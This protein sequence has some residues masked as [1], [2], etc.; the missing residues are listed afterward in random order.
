MKIIS[1]KKRNPD[2]YHSKAALI[3]QRIV[4][5]LVFA[6]MLS[7]GNTAAAKEIDGTKKTEFSYNKGDYFG[8]DQ[9]AKS[10]FYVECVNSDN[11]VF[12]S[13]SGFV[14]FDE[15]LFVTNQHVI[16]DASYLNIYDDDFNYYT[17]N[18]VVIS[19]AE[20]DIAILY[21]PS[22]KYYRSLEYDTSFEDLKRGQPILAIGSPQGMPGTVSDGIISAFPLFTGEDIR[23]IQITAPI[24]H[25]SS[26]GCLLNDD[27]KVIGVTSGG[28]D[29]GE[30]LGFAIPVFIVEEL[31]K[32]WNKKDVV[33]LG[34]ATSWDTVGSGLYRKISG[35][36]E[37][38]MVKPAPSPVST[39]NNTLYISAGQVPR[40]K[41]TAPSAGTYVFTS[42]GFE[43]T[44]G[45]LY[46]SATGSE[47]ASDDDSGTDRNFR[48]E[49]NLSANETI[50]IGVKY[51]DSSA[52][53]S[54]VLN[55]SKKEQIHSVSTGNNTISVSAGKTVRVSF[56][57]SSAG[58]YS[59]TTIGSADTYGYLYTSATGSE[60]ASDDDSGTDRN[61]RLERNLSANETIYIG[62]KYY[63]SSASGN[64]SLSINKEI[65]RTFELGTNIS[66]NNGRATVS[67]TDSDNR[68]P[69]EVAFECI[70]GG[71]AVS[72]P[73][74]W[75]G[76]DK[77]SSTTYS[78]SFTIDSLIPGKTYII[79]ITDCNNQRITKTYTIP[80]ASTFVDGKLPASSINISLSPRY[81]AY[82]ANYKSASPVNQLRASTIMNN[83]NSKEYGVRL[84]IDYP[85]LA[86][87][88][89]YFT[90][91]A[92][93]APNGY[94][95]CEIYESVDYGKD[96][97]G[98]YYYMLGNWTFAKMY[99]F[100]ST[101][102]SGTW[103]VELYWDGMFVKRSTFTVQ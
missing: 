26:G 22:G 16:R 41:F 90:Q 52:S 2:S 88:R 63:D 15:G 38:P 40:V 68:S 39:G 7:I 30:N 42:T 17:L 77:A 85:Q 35:S 59:F 66:M 28:I 54:T 101:I 50:Y 43:D 70:E 79:K 71:S 53:G 78:K 32:Q 46:T 29:E 6:L 67:W 82:G 14:M 36:A 80:S 96:Y 56:T 64:I 89:T 92:I 100:N 27:L 11:E 60:V 65:V 49:R 51:Y 97:S 93:I 73:S 31:Y 76:G 72:H 74:Y 61:F 37:K 12:A 48:L 3:K 5:A 13:G 25:G 86:Y 19:D 9:A 20:H 81:K 21:F 69:Y 34:S 57:A 44:Y 55:I 75:A 83:I 33:R 1:R 84:D 47:V 94:T 98:Y 58:K 24:S 4:L 45:Y 91:V 23:Y 102:P 103:A 10:V 8:I 62:V 18:Q 95:E 99:E 87:S